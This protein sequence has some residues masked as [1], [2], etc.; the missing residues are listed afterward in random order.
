MRLKELVEG[1]S[2][3]DDLMAAY[4]QTTQIMGEAMSAFLN[5]PFAID[6]GLAYM[7]TVAGLVVYVGTMREGV[8]RLDSYPGYGEMLQ[9]FLSARDS[10]DEKIDSLANDLQEQREGGIAKVNELKELMKNS[11]TS[12]PVI[13]GAS[14]ALKKRAEDALNK[15]EG[16][17]QELIQ[18]YRESNRKGRGGVAVPA[19]FS[20][21]PRLERVELELPLFAELDENTK[22]DLMERVE[23]FADK[24]HEEF[25]KIIS[26]LK[27][28]DKI[29]EESGYPF[30]VG[31]DNA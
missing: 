16:K 1:P 27:S 11:L 26:E 2:S 14:A 3:V 25:E 18:F 4:Q 13:L 23:S 28:V 10:Y 5:N 15:L 6:D 9:R 31:I 17:F 30:A 29:L 20:D 12:V 22:N 24:L 8:I 7:I 21:M 19:Y